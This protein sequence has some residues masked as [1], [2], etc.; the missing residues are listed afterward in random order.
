MN[1]IEIDWANDKYKEWFLA[2][3]SRN[4]KVII[5]CLVSKIAPSGCNIL[6]RTKSEDKGDDLYNWV[7][8]KNLVFLEFLEV[9]KKSVL[10]PDRPGKIGSNNERSKSK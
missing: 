6:L 1:R 2:I 3:H 7:A 4:D 5:E 9:K 8:K 10:I